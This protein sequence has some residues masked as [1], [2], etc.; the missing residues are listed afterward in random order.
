[1]SIGEA[2]ERFGRA[3]AHFGDLVHQI[4]DDQWG[5]PTP[6][7]DWD[8]RALVNHLVYEAKWAPPLLEGQSLEQVGS[9]FDGDLLGDDPE[10]SYDDAVADV[11]ATLNNPAAVGETVQLSYGETPAHEYVAQ[12][13]CDFVV[14]AWDLARGIGADDTL[15]P[16]M[17]QWVDDMARPQAAMLAASGMFGAP[18]NVPSD[19][20]PQTK[21]LALFGRT[22]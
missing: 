18:V 4:K 3:T 11:R 13:A 21:L 10:S 7:S 9:K 14:H 15:D 19:A 1:M 22:R 8:V 12:M 2:S 5:A 17:V 20:D 16:D 6:C